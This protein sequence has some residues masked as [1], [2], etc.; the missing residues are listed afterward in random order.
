LGAVLLKMSWLGRRNTHE[1]ETGSEK[2]YLAAEKQDTARD[3]KDNDLMRDGFSRRNR[4][5]KKGRRGT[6]RKKFDVVHSG[7]RR[8][9]QSKK[10]QAGKNE[11]PP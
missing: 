11:P 9:F 7:Q 1:R 3:A 5:Q 4:P 6:E 10:K 8:R 2:I